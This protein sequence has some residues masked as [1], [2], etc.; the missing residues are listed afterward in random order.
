MISMFV[1]KALE[2]LK[3]QKATNRII[4]ILV[5]L[6][7]AAIVGVVAYTKVYH[8]LVVVLVVSVILGIGGA[9]YAMKKAESRKVFH[10][11]DHL[12]KMKPLTEEELHD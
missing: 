6:S 11:Y 5:S 12:A 4:N 8:N 2:K 9:I 10:T 7:G 1:V 3:L